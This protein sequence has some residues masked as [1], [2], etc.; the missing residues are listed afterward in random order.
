MVMVGAE[1]AAE[2]REG[3]QKERENTIGKRSCQT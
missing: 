1:E 2:E 3:A